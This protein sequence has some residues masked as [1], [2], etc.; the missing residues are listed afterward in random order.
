LQKIDR[1]ILYVLIALVV[2]LPLVLRPARHP[3]IIFDEVS[4][5]YAVLENIP[6]DK[7]VIVSTVWGPGTEAE[8]APQTEVVMRH[9]FRNGKRFAVI[10][11]DQAGT[12]LTYEIGARLADEL[13]KEYGED[14]VHL[15]FRLPYSAVMRS[16]M[17]GMAQDFPKVI[18]YDRFNTKLDKIPAL[19]GVKTWKDIGAVVE[20]TPSA[21]VELWIS[22]FTGPYGIPMV[23]C[24]TAVMAAEAY[25]LLDAQ[26]IEG[27]LNGVIGAVQYETLLGMGDVATDASAISWALSAAHI[28]VIV[29]IILGNLGY[30][31]MRRASN[32]RNGGAGRG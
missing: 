10:S 14:W 2:T 17:R 15:G 20:I 29:L 24:P 4:K 9:L 26:L 11:W 5:A 30:L 32:G 16:I 1:R 23:F 21:T 6:D 22:Y 7:I 3:D 27:M 13:G 12:E 18:S 8:N 28:Y 31:A 19:D 25:P